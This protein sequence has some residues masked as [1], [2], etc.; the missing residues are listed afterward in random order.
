M[1]KAKLKKKTKLLRLQQKVRVLDLEECTFQES[2]INS[3]PSYSDNF[4]KKIVE[5]LVCQ[6]NQDSS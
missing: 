4:F 6:W 2:F 3:Q 1:A 5:E